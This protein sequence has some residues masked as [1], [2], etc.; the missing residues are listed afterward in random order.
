MQRR[1]LGRGLDA[2][3]PTV[4][5]SGD[6][7]AGVKPTDLQVDRILPNP[8]QPRRTIQSRAIQR[9]EAHQY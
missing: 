4:D 5:Q 8:Y 9:P 1:G 2:L 6:A 7:V 3:I